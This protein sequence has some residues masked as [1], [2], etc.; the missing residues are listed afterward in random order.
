MPDVAV[1]QCG[2][3][4]REAVCQA[5]QE[6]LALL[7][8]AEAVARPGQRVLLKV[9]LLRAA[10][11]ELA[12]T[13]HPEVVRA[14]GRLFL[15]AGCRVLVGDSSGG[16]DYGKTDEALKA[17]GIASVAEDEGFELV[18]FDTC[19]VARLDVPEGRFLDLSRR[20]RQVY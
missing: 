11:P 10:A 6:C 14:V 16:V 3:Y 4:D 8:G 1:V 2:R 7:G 5:M 18:N 13:T 9:S 20:S 17:C 19:G 15:N 12:V